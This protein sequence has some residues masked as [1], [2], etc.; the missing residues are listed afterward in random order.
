MSAAADI[1]PRVMAEAFFGLTS[2]YVI[3]RRVLGLG[4]GSVEVSAD[5]GIEQLFDLFWSGASAEK[6]R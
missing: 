5:S 3:M 4:E 1:D 2:S 6:G